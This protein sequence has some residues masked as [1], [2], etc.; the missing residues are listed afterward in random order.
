MYRHTH[1]THSMQTHR[2]SVYI[3]TRTHTHT[4]RELIEE[5]PEPKLSALNLNRKHTQHA[6]S[7]KKHQNQPIVAKAS[8]SEEKSSYHILKSPLSHSEKTSYG[9]STLASS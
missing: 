7:S 4:A 9:D 6:N 5:A 3:H 1:H 2:R 8:N